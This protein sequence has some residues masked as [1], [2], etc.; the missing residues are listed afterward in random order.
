MPRYLCYP[1]L[2]IVLT[3]HGF[4][5]WAQVR[6]EVQRAQPLG[7]RIA[8]STCGAQLAG[9]GSALARVISESGGIP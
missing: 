9:D 3:P 4:D 1:S 7:L 6:Q 8:S 5:L 2:V